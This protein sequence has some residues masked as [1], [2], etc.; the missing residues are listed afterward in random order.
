M[1]IADLATI[2]RVNYRFTERP[3]SVA[4]DLRPLWR[5]ASVCVILSHCRAQT[6]TLKQLHVLNWALRDKANR[7]LFLATLADAPPVLPIVRIEPSLNRAVDLALGETLIHRIN[8]AT[9]SRIEL[10]DK[11]ASLAK[12][13]EE[14]AE[15]FAEEKA[16]FDA[17]GRKVTS[18]MIDRILQWNNL[19]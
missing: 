10:A 18:V 8:S 9:G 3:V 14:T 13:I 7:D 15:A 12:K 11:G 2:Y 1:Q 5:F 6:A 16:F 19:L 17:I 4:G